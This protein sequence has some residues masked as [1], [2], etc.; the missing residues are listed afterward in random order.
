M[1]KITENPDLFGVD[2][3]MKTDTVFDLT[4]LEAK[5]FIY[6]CKLD[7]CLPTL[8]VFL[9]QLMVRYKI[10]EYNSKISSELSKFNSNWFC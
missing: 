8:S 4:I 1:S 7:N 2:K 9:Q 5:Q 6:R 10:E 3:D